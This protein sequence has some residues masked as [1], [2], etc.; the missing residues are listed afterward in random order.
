LEKTWPVADQPL[1]AERVF[2][3]VGLAGSSTRFNLGRIDASA[4]AA[5]I[6]EAGDTPGSLL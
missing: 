4:C 6:F 3:F 1:G 2:G 5:E